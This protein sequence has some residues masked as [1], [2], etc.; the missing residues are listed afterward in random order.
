MTAVK[1]DL[2]AVLPHV[3][4]PSPPTRAF[5]RLINLFIAAVDIYALFALVYLGARLLMGERW[6]PVNVGNN[7]MPSL[8]I[9]AVFLWVGMGLLRRWRTF[10]L[11]SPSFAAFAGLYG[12]MML[13]KSV[14]IPPDA[15]TLTIMTWNL[16]RAVT[17]D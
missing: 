13:P 11:L 16:H 3:D 2:P 17:S 6:Q 10:V 8:L 5:T 14:Q 4:A 1:T 9:P 12:A 7:L 15:P